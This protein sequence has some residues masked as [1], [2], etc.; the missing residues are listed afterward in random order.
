MRNEFLK[1]EA[2]VKSV[3]ILYFLFGGMLL[4]SQISM[5]SMIFSM[6]PEIGVFMVFTMILY[7]LVGIGFIFIG[8]GLRKLRRWVRIPVSIFAGLGLLGFPFGTLISLYI[9]YLIWCAKGKM[10]FSTEYAEIIEATPD[11]K[12]KTSFITKLLVACLFIAF[13]AAILIPAFTT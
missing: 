6:T 13:L 12:L 2:L 4:I 3:G 1:H 10:V 5:I 8:V 9:L 11:I 7:L